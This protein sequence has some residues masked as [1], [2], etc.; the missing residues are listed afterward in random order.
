VPSRK[1]KKEKEI[2]KLVKDRRSVTRDSMDWLLG[3]TL[4]YPTFN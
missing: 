4:N 3:D 2:K 1:G